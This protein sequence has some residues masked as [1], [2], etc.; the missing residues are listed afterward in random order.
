MEVR[1][2]GLVDAKARAFR[3]FTAPR[4]L[5]GAGVP[6]L[7][8]SNQLRCPLPNFFGSRPILGAS[9]LYALCAVRFVLSKLFG[10]SATKFAQNTVHP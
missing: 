6:K 2:S 5:L 7:A 1:N 3:N 4:P 9:V 10:R 8:A